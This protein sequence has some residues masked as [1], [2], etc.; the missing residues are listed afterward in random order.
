MKQK[1]IKGRR[2]PCPQPRGAKGPGSCGVPQIQP[3]RGGAAGA[4]GAVAP[5]GQAPAALRPGG[6]HPPH[7]PHPPPSA[8]WRPPRP[9]GGTARPRS[10]AGEAVGAAPLAQRLSRCEAAGEGGCVCSPPFLTTP[11]VFW[12]TL[13]LLVGPAGGGSCPCPSCS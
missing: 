9:G 2:E 10:G 11:G 13:G 6:L 8:R 5:R 12:L 1:L 7:P 4:G 3:Q